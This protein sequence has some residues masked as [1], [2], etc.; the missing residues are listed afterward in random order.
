MSARGGVRTTCPYCGVG[1]GVLARAGPA[2]AAVA[3]DPE[4][5]ANR[6]RLCSKGT[7]LADTL[8]LGGRLLH[9]VVDGRRTGWDAA[10][11][12]VAGTFAETVRAHGPDSVAFYVSGQLLTEDYYVANKLMKG[13]IGGANIDTNSR[14]CM[15]SAVAGHKR[16]FGA[17]T[18][19]GVYADLEEAD[20]VVLV[21]SNLSWCHPV[22]HQRLA[23]ARAARRTRV[24]V[25]DPRRT[26]T[27]D[28]AD[29]HLPLAAGSD[30][31]L[32]GGL[33]AHL[34]RTGAVDSAYVRRHVSGAG[35][36]L[37]AARELTPR[38]A[39]RLTGLDAG[40]L[41][42]FY[43]MFAET[44]RVV[45][46][47]SQ[48]VNQ[49]SAGTDKVNAILNCHLA[50][51]RIGRPGMG[52]FSVTGQPNAMGGREV[53]GLANM[54]AAHM[55]IADPAH[56]RIVRD[57]WQAPRIATRPGLR[58][59][60]L[61]EAVATGRVRALWIMATNPAVSLPRAGAVGPALAR[62]PFVVVSDVVRGTDTARHADVLLPS[63][64]WGEKDGTVTNSER[65]ISRQR[66]FL[67]A[68]GEARADWWQVCEVAR[69]MGFARAF[70]YRHPAE[71][72]AEHAALSG[73]G[74]DGG[75]DFDIS[76]YA[77]ITR[78]AYDALEPF[79]WPRP[80]G[81][82]A[83]GP[84]F[85]ADGGF[86]TRDRRA[87]MVP[88]PYRAPASS[89]SPRFP[90]VLNTGRIRDQWHT[91]TR[92]AKSATL[93]SH[94]PEPF[95]EVHPEDAAR[96]GIEDAALVRV[97]SRHGS[98]VLR[99]VVT[100]ELRPGTVFAP[101][102]WSRQHASDASVGTLV[103]AHTDPVSAQPEFKF[104]P[105][106][107]APFK[108]AWH[109]FAATLAR[110]STAGADYWAVART[111]T[112]WRTELAARDAPDDWAGAARRILGAGPA[113]ELV[114]YCD[115]AAGRHRF[116]CYSDDRL[117]GVLF[118]SRTPVPETRNWA[119]ARIGDAQADRWTVLAGQAGGTVPDVG[120]IVCACFQVGQKQ[121]A[122]AVESGACAS[123][124]DVG[125]H[126]GA[127]TN[128]GS[129]RPEIARLVVEAG[130][131]GAT[132]AAAGG[133]RP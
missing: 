131:T 80:A 20:L 76:A 19:P 119:V 123:V 83:P 82:A 23:A 105:V 53:G 40:P 14:L 22:L 17:D 52:P 81:R 51:G 78:P 69:R 59:V 93:M 90:L 109:G 48:G 32:L 41:A 95:V 39:A 102:H 44:E 62:C 110:P 26:A 27:C 54:L 94:R 101:I 116:A 92:T 86:F 60:E 120:A 104:T 106:A 55:E 16:A 72:F 111:A 47:F 18:V 10:L 15:A 127:G 35:A 98:A 1:C 28:L 74:N 70:P 66:P 21:G 64:A 91:M 30:V 6:G 34:E 8:A 88:T 121:I 130:A 122:G 71:I 42:A 103:G 37:E 115:H 87:V 25:V 46:L 118:V 7:H 50:T 97:S 57:F 36:A 5:P 108:A 129:C 67:P 124:A 24:V 100:S 89:V 29:L 9:P 63:T 99:A 117:A 43:R 77:G 79:R 31:A 2:G 85:F 33:L 114:T 133:R 128:C 113:A 65:C 12:R 132:E 73:A 45:T 4:H 49:S 3:G 107:V 84:R 11:Q 96:H 112:G 13:F 58:A 38:K 68:P 126:L 56:R 61:F 125:V 75:R